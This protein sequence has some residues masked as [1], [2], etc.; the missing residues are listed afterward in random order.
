M[1]QL[2]N[3][4]KF[5]ARDG[6]VSCTR[7]HSLLETRL[8]AAKSAAV[9]DEILLSPACSG[10]ERFQN[11]QRNGERI[12]RF[13]KSISWGAPAECPNING[14]MCIELSHIEVSVGK[15]NFSPR[16]FLRENRSANN[17]K[18]HTSQK[19]AVARTSK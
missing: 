10:F 12:C 2:N 7:R 4:K 5:A 3:E 15:N 14:T 18:N 19:G 13:A 1:Q 9:G 11:F 17:R 16:V 6:F 8:E